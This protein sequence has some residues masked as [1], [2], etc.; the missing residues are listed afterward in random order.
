MPP[1][2]LIEN[3]ILKTFNLSSQRFGWTARFSTRFDV[4]IPVKCY[5]TDLFGHASCD[6]SMHVCIVNSFDSIHVEPFRFS[7]V[8]SNDRLCDTGK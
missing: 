1:L 4:K 2:I 3:C 6:E 8:H 5:Y 7:N